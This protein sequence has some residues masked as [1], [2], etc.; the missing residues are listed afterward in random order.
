MDIGKTIT[1]LRKSKEITQDDL[2]KKCNITQAYLSQIEKNKKEPNMS[3]V[4][5]I[6]LALGVPLAVL[7]FMALESS[8]VPE[9]KQKMFNVMKPSMSGFFETIF[10]HESNSNY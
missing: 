8:D 7:F 9:N 6:A 10:E 5:D 4:K 3:T 2:A 1:H